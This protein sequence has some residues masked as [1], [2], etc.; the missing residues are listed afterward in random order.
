MLLIGTGLLFKSMLILQ[1][2]DPGY[3]PQNVMGMRIDL[4]KDRYPTG[5]VRTEFM[6]RILAQVQ[7]LPGVESAAITY[8]DPKYSLSL[9]PSTLE[10]K[11]TA[12][13]AA[14]V[15]KDESWSNEN[16]ISP[17]YFRTLS[18]PIIRGREFTNKDREGAPRVA[19]VNRNQRRKR[20]DNHCGDCGGCLWERR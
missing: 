18:I 3:R 5:L 17:D 6:E 13:I 16:P 20:L 8:S 14:D 9:S 19:I 1:R 10:I 11:G 12:K 7:N 15:K 2:I 4:T